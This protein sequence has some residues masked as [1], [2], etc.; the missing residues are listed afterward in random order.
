MKQNSGFT[1]IEL[2]IVVAVIGVLA[3]IAI[4][5]YQDYV[6]RSKITQALSGLSDMRVKMERHF[7]DNRTYVGACVAGTQAPL[8]ANTAN[9]T[10]SCTAADLTTTTYTVDATGISSMTGFR[11]RID[12]DNVRTTESLPAGWTAPA[13]NC[14]AL[15]RSGGC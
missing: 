10:F 7:Q 15:N 12:Q 13:T 8:P 9:F 5:N 2:M 14:W 11:Y 3:A 1:L 4:P 6:T